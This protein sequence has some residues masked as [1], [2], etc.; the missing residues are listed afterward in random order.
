LGKASMELAEAKQL[1]LGLVSAGA[2]E[3]VKLEEALGRVLADTISAH[4]DLPKEPRSRLDGFALS[5]GSTKNASPEAPALLEI[6]EGGLAAG[7]S[8]ENVVLQ[9]GKCIHILTGAPLP[10]NADS[11]AAQ[12]EASYGENRI[13]LDRPYTPGRGVTP[14]GE[15]IRRGEPV[16]A[17]GCVLGPTRL[18][19]IAALG[20]PRALVFARPRVALLATGDEVRELGEAHNGPTTFCNNR[21]LLAW[22]VR[23][24]GGEPF[25][26]G[27]VGDDPRAIVDRL[28]KVDADFILTTGGIGSGDRDFIL[29]SWRELGVRTLFYRT[30]LSPGGN[31]A[32][33]AR[34]KQIF[35]A[36]SGNPWAARVAFEELI[37]P[38]LRRRQGLESVEAAEITA[39]LRNS[40]KKRK[41][42]YRAISGKLDAL[43]SPPSF[44]PI[45]KDES[46]LFFMLRESFVYTLL[47]P[48][49]TEA[50]VGE[51]V[52]VRF[53]DLPLLGLPIFGPE[54]TATGR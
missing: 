18:A 33:G 3:W 2:T 24:Q 1:A 6:Q 27:V 48:H 15:E 14:A 53:H 35:C 39:I 37:S 29:S 54:K 9:Q 20:H 22:L 23:L 19:L 36:L 8:A 28:A 50:S 21:H 44:I 41:G 12:E 42:V 17:D 4:T 38:M 31:C 5:S 26:L 46:S 52:R 51:A 49:R 10:P 34:G 25:S 16:L 40:I 45:E 11:V 43:T 30:N 7:H 13:H 32:L 47:E